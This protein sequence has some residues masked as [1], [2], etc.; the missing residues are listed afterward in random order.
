MEL[1]LLGLI[2]LTLGLGTTGGLVV[3]WSLH[4]RWRSLEYRVLDLEE[5]LTSVKAREKAHKRWE[6]SDEQ[7][8]FL[9]SLGSPARRE[10]YANDFVGVPDGPVR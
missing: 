8:E 5:R 3:T 4:R 9:K 6:K 10:H 2:A 7:D 1:G